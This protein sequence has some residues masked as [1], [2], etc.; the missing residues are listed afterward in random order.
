MSD[1]IGIGGIVRNTTKMNTPAGAMEE[2]VNLR[3][4]EGMLRPLCASEVIWTEIASETDK[5][6][7]LFLHTGST[8]KHLLGVRKGD[9]AIVHVA[10]IEG[11]EAGLVG[12]ETGVSMQADEVKAHQMGNLVVVADGVGRLRY[13]LWY[14]DHYEE[15]D[16]THG[17]WLNGQP[18]IRIKPA[19]DADGVPEILLAQGYIAESAYGAWDL[20]ETT[21]SA[22][23]LSLIAQARTLAKEQG[24]LNGFCV[25]VVAMKMYDGTYAYASKPVLLPQANDSGTRYE[26]GAVSYKNKPKT[27]NVYQYTCESHQRAPYAYGE[28]G[29]TYWNKGDWYREIYQNPDDHYTGFYRGVRHSAGLFS[30]STADNGSS[31]YERISLYQRDL[32]KENNIKKHKYLNIEEEDH[33][34]FGFMVNNWND[35]VYQDNAYFDVDA[36][37]RASSISDDSQNKMCGVD[38]FNPPNC[39]SIMGRLKKGQGNKAG[40][41]DYLRPRYTEAVRDDKDTGWGVIMGNTIQIKLPKPN[42]DMEEIISEVCLFVSSEVYYAEENNNTSKSVPLYRAQRGSV[43][44]NG[45]CVYANP[46]ED[47]ELKEDIEKVSVFYNV[48]SENYKSI[49]S[50]EWIDIDLKNKLNILEQLETLNVD[51]STNT[52]RNVLR[53][54]CSYLYNGRLHIG[55]ITEET[56][57]GFG[58]EVLRQAEPCDINVWTNFSK[59][60]LCSSSQHCNQPFE[61]SLGGTYILRGVPAYFD[62]DYAGKKVETM[63]LWVVVEGLA[64]GAIYYDGSYYDVRYDKEDGCYKS[65]VDGGD[66]IVTNIDLTNQVEAYNIFKAIYESLGLTLFNS[67]SSLKALNG[68]EKLSGLA[69]AYKT[70]IEADGHNYKRYAVC[71]GWANTTI[72]VGA[73]RQFIIVRIKTDEGERQTGVLETNTTRSLLNPL[74][75]Y[76]DS[77]ADRMTIGYVK[78]AENGE[79]VFCANTYKLRAF[80]ALEGAVC[81]SDDVKPIYWWDGTT[82]YRQDASGQIWEWKDEGWT[83]Q[84]EYTEALFA[85][86]GG[87]LAV[88][89]INTVEYRPNVMKVSATDTPL[90]FPAVN[91]YQVGNGRI[92]GFCSNTVGLSTGQW[93]QEP[94]YAFCSD[95]IFAFSVDASGAMVYPNSRPISREVC[96][97]AMSITPIDSAVVFSSERGLQMISGSEVTEISQPIEG[98][99]LRFAEGGH[100][101]RL[102]SAKL[103]LDHEAWLGIPTAPTAEEAKEYLKKARI[104]W[105][106]DNRELWVANPE[107]DYAYIFCE[108]MWSKVMRRIRYFVNDYPSTYYVSDTDGLVYDMGRDDTTEP[109]DTMFLTRPIVIGG[110]TAKTFTRAWLYADLNVYDNG[111]VSGQTEMVAAGDVDAYKLRHKAA[112]VVYGS[113]DGTRYSMIGIGGVT[114]RTRDIVAKLHRMAMRYVRVM[115]VGRLWDDSRLECFMLQEKV[116]WGGESSVRVR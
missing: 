49:Q 26:E 107:K 57:E 102:D 8:Y 95:G 25:A 105:N 101:D 45:A 42:P 13:L 98:Y 4:R 44:E 88:N 99:Y 2:I 79:V 38:N 112:L 22:N 96:N 48:W 85:T 21:V 73:E 52:V 64:L 71:P 74:L 61:G 23:G 47:K 113:A 11:D 14:R 65:V 70:K 37:I 68:G 72:E 24:W 7:Q 46:K 63:A 94:L 43:N 110:E 53:A 80:S 32:S 12:V 100:V 36:G 104:G 9:C 28:G 115:F 97:N 69:A 54:K 91:T 103:M 58:F 83:E 90:V 109:V 116:A 55:D 15:K 1:T 40:S 62:V 6:S 81:V 106:Y 39:F 10:N 30:N 51:S 87:T 31:S 77:R 93:G 59:E 33:V 75:F 56:F 27:N 60:Y 66:Y 16:T 29:R 92:V 18:E 50:D 86:E 41:W 19:M 34:P 108:G 67:V 3:R 89:K 78:S 76:P 17:E 35:N 84:E 20:S 111:A 5:Y 82:K 114:G